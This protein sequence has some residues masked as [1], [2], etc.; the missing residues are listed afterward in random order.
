MLPLVVDV[1]FAARVVYLH[2]VHPT[3]LWGHEVYEGCP[4]SFWPHIVIGRT[5]WNYRDD[6]KPIYSHTYWAWWH[7][8]DVIYFRNFADD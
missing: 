5:N 2:P 8:Y 6:W 3:L 4:K 1:L 7:K